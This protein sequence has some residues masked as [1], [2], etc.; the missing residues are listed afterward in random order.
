ME[1]GKEREASRSRK[2]SCLTFHFLL[3]GGDERKQ[4]SHGDG[5]GGDFGERQL[6]QAARFHAAQ[7]ETTH[8]QS[9]FLHFT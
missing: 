7:M 1:E 6:S 2:E 5:D 9:R 8:A 3:D 4:A